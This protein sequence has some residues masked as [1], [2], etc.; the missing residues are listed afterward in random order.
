MYISNYARDNPWREDIAETYVVW[1]ATR[2][3]PET[4]T[5]AE[6]EEWET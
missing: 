3:S 6:L 5:D 4:F 1:F 2:Y